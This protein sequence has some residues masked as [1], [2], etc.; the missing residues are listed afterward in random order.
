MPKNEVDERLN[1]YC[2]IIEDKIEEG[3]SEEEAVAEIGDIDEIASQIAGDIPHT[4]NV[5][6]KLKP[7]HRLR[8]WEIVVIVLG[9]PVWFSLL[10]AVFAVAFSVYISI[11]SVIVSL[12]AVFASLVGTAVA[13]AILCVVEFLSGTVLSGFVILSVV[14]I[15]AGL[16]VY[17]FIGCRYFTKGLA[18]L[19]VSM[20]KWLKRCFA[21]REEEQ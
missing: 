8:G 2:E 20:M 21:K 10:V 19:T 4:K 13:G 5:K 7:R 6:E 3:L 18:K 16:S 17:S 11:W 1:F 12:W 14:L 15:C 9:F